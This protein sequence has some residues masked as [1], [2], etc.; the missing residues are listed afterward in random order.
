MQTKDIMT[1]KDY[2]RFFKVVEGREIECSLREL[3]PGDVFRKEGAEG[4]WKATSRP[5]INEHQTATVDAE[6]TQLLL[7]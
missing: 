7:S 2:A 3:R 5:Y 1:S 4:F 6:P